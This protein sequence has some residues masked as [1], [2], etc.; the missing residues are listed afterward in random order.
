MYCSKC[1]FQNNEGNKFCIKCGT[2]L[3]NNAQQPQQQNQ[4][5][6]PQ[7][8]INNST[9]K[10]TLTRP[11]NFVGSLIKF[12]I[13]IDNNEVGTIKNDETV[14]LNVNSG[15]HTI[16]F[17][18]TMN[19]NINITNDTYADVVVIAGNKF[20]ITNIR[21]NTGQSVQNN[22][23]YTENIDKVIKSAKGPLIF[24]CACIAL[25][26][27]LLFTINMVV[28]PI[29]YGISIGYTVISMSSIKKQKENLKEK[30]KSLMTLNIISIVVSVIGIIISGFLIIG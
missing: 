27:I 12:K 21:D 2:I 23:V 6:Q 16:S 8:N 11:K 9:Y 17:N 30:Y 24:S 15:N 7:E 14:V 26:F 5:V 1:G 10:L 29:T 4:F 18:K 20:G 3:E 13:Y 25:T 22:E 19:Q 28:S